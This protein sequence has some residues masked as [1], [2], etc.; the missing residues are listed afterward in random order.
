MCMGLVKI[1][2]RFDI[3]FNINIGLNGTQIKNLSLNEA[4]H[5]K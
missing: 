3:M 4:V 2:I 5:L 1:Q